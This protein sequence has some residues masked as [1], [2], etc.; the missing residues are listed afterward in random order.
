M[1]RTLP[2]VVANV[3]LATVIA[4]YLPGRCAARREVNARLR[5]F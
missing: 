4:A 3:A 5:H 1:A 2:D